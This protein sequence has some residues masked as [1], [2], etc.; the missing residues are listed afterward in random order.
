MQ[1]NPAGTNDMSRTRMNSGTLPHLSGVHEPN[2]LAAQATNL[3]R[4][5]V[6]ERLARYMSQAASTPLPHEA[7]ERTKEHVLDTIASMVS[8]MGLPPGRQGMKFIE[9]YGGPPVATV[10]G[11]R[12]RC[13]PLEA[14]MANAMLAHSDETD[15]SHAPSQSHPGCGVV[16]AA[17]A[18]S[19]NFGVS[20]V[21]FLRAVALGYDVG[22][23]VSMTLGAEDYQTHFHR[24]THCICSVFGAGAAA[25]CA[26]NL[27]AQ[28]MR[29]VLDY[30]AQQASGIAAWQRD[31][32]HIE[33]ALVFGGFAARDALSTA[34]LIH[35]GATGVED[36]FAGPDNFF[37]AFKPDADPAGLIDKLGE[38]YEVT[39]T[40]I[41]KWTVGSPIQAVLDAIEILLRKHHFTPAQV[42]EA[43]VRVASGEAHIVDNREMPDI[44]LQHMVALMITDGTVTFRSAHDQARMQDPAI[45]ELRSRVRLVYDNDLQQLYPKRVAIVQVTLTDGTNLSQRVDAVRGSAENPMSRDEVIAK[46]RDLMS[47]SMGSERCEHLITAIEN[48]DKESDIRKL[49]PMLQA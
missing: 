48:I 47:P 30:S 35:Q 37:L 5:S 9:A 4:P 45:R 49:S 14:A 21:H 39:R 15:D 36:V 44:C 40:N 46:A 27:S 3:E 12:M 43:V 2:R 20:G 6:I 18:A 13:G 32:Q 19:E 28:Q 24:D 25:A 22:T 7:A 34:L 31:T 33:K 42:R 11:S 10:V 41:K 16:P 38:R 29:W 17:L 8:G 26:A 23:R 1:P